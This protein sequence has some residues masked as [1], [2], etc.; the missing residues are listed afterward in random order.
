MFQRGDVVQYLANVGGIGDRLRWLARFAEKDVRQV[1]PSSL[2]AGRQHRFTPDQ[3]IDQQMGIGQL[4]AHLR[5]FAQSRIS[6]RQG[7]DPIPVQRQI[8]WW[9]R[10]DKRIISGRMA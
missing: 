2:N 10:R 5:Q 4:S 3:G 1:R 7:Q 9:Q 6:L 8:K